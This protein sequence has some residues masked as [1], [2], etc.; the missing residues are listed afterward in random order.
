MGSCATSCDPTNPPAYAST[1]QPTYA[2][3]FGAVTFNVSRWAFSNLGNNTLGVSGSSGVPLMAGPGVP[4]CPGGSFAVTRTD[5]GGCP[6]TYS[7]TGSFTSNT[8]WSGTFR[9]SFSGPNCFDCTTRSWS[10]IGSR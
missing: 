3:A 5:S 6:T 1:P 4:V 9:V 8:Q 10:V 7:L 2:C